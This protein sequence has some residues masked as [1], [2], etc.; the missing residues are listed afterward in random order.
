MKPALHQLDTP[1]LVLDIEKATRNAERMRARCDYLGVSFRPHVKTPK[2][3]DLAK[4][5]LGATTGP[6]TVSTIYEAEHFAAND[7]KN[8]L[9]ATAIVAAKLPKVVAIQQDTGAQVH[10][11]LDSVVTAKDLAAFANAQSANFSV[12]IEIDC[13]EHR[14]GISA[15]DAAL[16]E[17]AE[18]LSS[19]PTVSLVGVMAHAGHSYA[20]DNKEALRVIAAGERDAAVA[21][22]KTLRNKGY[23]CPQVSIGSTPTILHADHLQGVTEARCGVYLLW[24]LAQASRHICDL[25][26]IAAAV[27]AT[28]IGHNRAGNAIIVDVGALALSKDI[29][30]NKFMPEAHYGLICDADTCKPLTPLAVTQVHQEHGTISVPEP[31][32]FERLP[33]GSKVLVMPNHICMTAAAYTEFNVLQDGN[34]V[35]AW[36]RINGW[37]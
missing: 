13:G 14:S 26:D 24:D 1:C 12:Y 33:I 17:I 30:A 27:L 16:L 31:I 22:S 2:S 28:V 6:I 3:I 4:L 7:F 20:T 5:A 15:D 35:G 23:A 34:I 19:A 32:W 9:Y 21:A 25:S 36:Q 10:V 18:T 11:V 8:I 29:G 37:R